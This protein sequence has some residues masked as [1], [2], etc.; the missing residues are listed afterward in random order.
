MCLLWACPAL[1]VLTKAAPVVVSVAN[2]FGHLHI[3]VRV[4]DKD[5]VPIPVHGWLDPSEVVAVTV[6]GNL[7]L[8]KGFSH[9]DFND[10]SW[11]SFSQLSCLKIC[12]WTS[13]QLWS[14]KSN[15]HTV[16]RQFLCIL[17]KWQESWSKGSFD[18]WFGLVLSQPL[19]LDFKLCIN[20]QWQCQW[21]IA[22]L[23]NT[24]FSLSYACHMR[25]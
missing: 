10:L 18:R 22:S 11:L 4:E 17:W 21:H 1:Q 15:S 7:F 20:I 9:L 14:K 24:A 8:V 5:L 6:M 25:Q 16:S 3:R 12:K 2:V 13:C 23:F 19:H